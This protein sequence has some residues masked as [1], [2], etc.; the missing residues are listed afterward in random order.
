M[1]QRVIE[2]LK[3]HPDEQ[4]QL[5][6]STWES[7]IEDSPE[8]ILESLSYVDHGVRSE[9]A[10][11][12]LEIIQGGHPVDV[13]PHP[14]YGLRINPLTEAALAERLQF[15]E[16]IPELRTA[17]PDENTIPAVPIRNPDGI[18]S[19]VM[20]G[21]MLE[22]AK[23]DVIGRIKAVRENLTTDI[24]AI[25]PAPSEYPICAPPP[26]AVV[27]TPPATTAL[28]LTR[29]QEQRLLWTTIAT[30]KGI[31]TITPVMYDR[32]REHL[33][34]QGIECLDGP[35][36]DGA[37]LVWQHDA[38]PPQG[39]AADLNPSFAFLESTCRS[40]STRLRRHC[41][42]AG[43]ARGTLTVTPH[44]DIAARRSGWV[45]TFHAQPTGALPCP[46]ST[47]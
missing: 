40:V 1:I 34:R 17:P 44:R 12:L 18:L 2:A 38:S 23:E 22:Q 31:Q 24:A 37:I 26:V 21:L 42:E 39:G 19:Q 20:L 6:G 15:D 35:I 45:V 14:T 7:N 25:A 8:R 30:A 5:L 33:Q 46:S 28:H 10:R 41:E 36:P 3:N 29:P 27:P 9:V 13:V 43:V 11:V 47:P 16:D 4:C 32:M